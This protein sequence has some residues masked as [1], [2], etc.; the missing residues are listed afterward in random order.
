[1]ND[2]TRELRTL[3]GREEAPDVAAPDFLDAVKT[4][5]EGIKPKTTAEMRAYHFAQQVAPRLKD[6][7]FDVRYHKLD[8]LA[9]KDER[10]AQQRRVLRQVKDRFT[11]CGSIVALVGPRGT[12]K[13]SIAAEFAAERIWGDWEI[14]TGIERK[15]VPC[16]VTS[17]R[18]AS[19]L[20]ARFKAYYGDFGTIQMD[21]LQASLD[22]LCSVDVLV[23]DEVHEVPED[24]RH[25]D[26]LMTDLLD[27]RYS[28]RKDTLL[29]SNQKKPDFWQSTPESIKSRITEHGGIIECVWDSFRDKPAK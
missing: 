13:T 10:C 16:R 2:F 1:M 23:I 12:G 6:F 9:G 21:Q 29:I 7:G 25:K 11:N 26:R 14:A 17:Y 15:P 27:K 4:M 18:K 22:H 24:S 5:L 28:A 8:L 20:I 3:M 19:D